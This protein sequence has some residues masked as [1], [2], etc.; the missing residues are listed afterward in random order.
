MVW[1]S[2]LDVQH[3]VSTP[4]DYEGS[5]FIQASVSVAVEVPFSFTIT[6]EELPNLPAEIFNWTGAFDGD[7]TCASYFS[8]Q[9]ANFLDPSGYD[10]CSGVNLNYGV[11]VELL[12]APD[13][14]D[15]SIDYAYASLCWLEMDTWKC[16]TTLPHPVNTRHFL[17][18]GFL[19][20]SGCG[21]A[22]QLHH[23]G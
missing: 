1:L 11:E 3:S 19:C 23:R 9:T 22:I 17:H 15:F 4:G 13:D 16:S 20:V 2:L 14:N 10:D 6:D 8:Y 5:F 12:L 18:S 21:G 7:T